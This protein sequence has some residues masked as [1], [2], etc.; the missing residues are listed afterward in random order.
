[1]RYFENAAGLLATVL[2]ILFS[3]A[4]AYCVTFF[5]SIRAAVLLH[6]VTFVDI[7]NLTVAIVPRMLLTVS[8]AII[9]PLCALRCEKWIFPKRVSTPVSLAEERHIFLL[10]FA[11]ILA[12]LMVLLFL[13]NR[14][15][16]LYNELYVLITWVLL[17]GLCISIV[18][19][20][21]FPEDAHWRF[22]VSLV[23]V[24]PPVLMV[25]VSTLAA[26]DARRVEACE[27][28]LKAIHTLGEN[29]G[30]ISHE[31]CLMMSLERGLLLYDRGTK[32]ALLIP[33]RQVLQ[34]QDP[35]P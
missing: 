31:A 35:G 10:T 27:R 2:A 16:L 33:W 26:E 17:F 29:Q 9:V 34:I 1:M 5:L 12:L 32:S 25:V 24:F 3:I 23:V 22:Y 19:W 14:Q 30:P 6:H 15:I 13:V 21:S 4:A 18:I 11:L 28:P 8:A 7:V 20:L